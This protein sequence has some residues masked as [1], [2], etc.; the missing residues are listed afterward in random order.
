MES[1]LAWSVAVGGSGWQRH[2]R[3]KANKSPFTVLVAGPIRE[4]MA[5]LTN[6]TMQPINPVLPPRHDK[7]EE[8]TEVDSSGG[9]G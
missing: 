1:W 7:H 6:I 5:T 2:S 9:P 4:R 3:T 8:K